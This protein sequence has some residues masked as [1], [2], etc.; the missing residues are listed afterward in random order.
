[1]GETLPEWAIKKGKNMKLVIS[2]AALCIT[3][4]QVVH[5]SPPQPTKPTKIEMIKTDF[6][7]RGKTWQYQFDVQGDGNWSEIKTIKKDRT[8]S[9]V[10]GKTK[11]KIIPS[12]SFEQL[13]TQ[14]YVGKKIAIDK[15]G[16]I[17]FKTL[18]EIK[19]LIADSKK[20]SSAPVVIP[21]KV[22]LKSP[23]PIQLWIPTNKFPVPFTVKSAPEKTGAEYNDLRLVRSNNQTIKHAGVDHYVVDLLVEKIEHGQQKTGSFIRINDKPGN[24]IIIRNR[25]KIGDEIVKPIKD[26]VEADS[27]VKMG[28]NNNFFVMSSDEVVLGK[29]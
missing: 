11:L 7:S 8:I 6:T 15:D 10:P 4:A 9:F 1:M 27:I 3:L 24:Q 5:C 20:A 22:S 23:V 29:K 2:V 25:E 19:Q 14:D 21:K 28:M 26:N 18:A 17:H 16:I 12:A 13:I